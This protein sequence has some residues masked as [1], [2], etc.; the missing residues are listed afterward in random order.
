M[1]DVDE[2]ED[3][4]LLVGDP[5]GPEFVRVCWR[6][7]SPELGASQLAD[8]VLPVTVLVTGSQ[9]SL[10]PSPQ[11]ALRAL[12]VGVTQPLPAKQAFGDNQVTELSWAGLCL[13][14]ACPDV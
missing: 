4:A 12:S 11:R 8:E 9:S 7:E 6:E 1:F 10:S 13:Y 2:T 3:A 5:A 14:R